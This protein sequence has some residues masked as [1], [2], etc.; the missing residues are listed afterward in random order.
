MFLFICTFLIVTTPTQPLRNIN[1][2]CNWVWHENAF[3]YHPT[4]PYH[5]HPILS[6]KK[7]NKRTTTTKPTT[8]MPSACWAAKNLVTLTN[9]YSR[10]G[11]RKRCLSICYQKGSKLLS[12]L[13]TAVEWHSQHKYILNSGQFGD[14]HNFGRAE[15]GLDH[16]WKLVW[17][18][19]R[20]LELNSEHHMIGKM[21]E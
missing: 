17:R 8:T 19:W 7:L 13:A 21:L 3:A 15:G 9:W 16:C 5:P 6:S 14:N 4:P 11:R 10:V 1:L 2:I 20:R 12:G 18:C